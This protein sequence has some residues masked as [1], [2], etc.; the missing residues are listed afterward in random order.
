MNEGLQRKTEGLYLF[1]GFGFLILLTRLPLWAS[2]YT[3][4]D[5]T[6]LGLALSHYDLAAHRPHP[7]GYLFYVALGRVVHYLGLSP[8][9][10][11]LLL[12]DLF[13]VVGL[14]CVAAMVRPFTG[15]IG[16]VVAAALWCF[17]PILW[18]YGIVGESYA[19]EGACSALVGLLALRWLRTGRGLLTLSLAVGLCGGIRSSVT[20]FTFPLWLY[21]VLRR[22]PGGREMIYA[23]IS[24]AAGIV[25]WALPT[26]L[27]AGGYHAYSELS[28]ALIWEYVGRINS[29]FLS[30]DDRYVWL[31]IRACLYWLGATID[32]GGACA[33]FVALAAFVKGRVAKKSTVSQNTSAVEEKLPWSFVFVWT[34]P[35][36]LFFVLMFASKP[37]YF[38]VL[39]PAA[40]FVTS[41]II[42]HSINRLTVAPLFQRWAPI[43]I[44]LVLV[45][46]NVHLFLREQP[47][48]GRPI[49]R[50]V[51]LLDAMLRSQ[52]ASTAHL[53][54]LGGPR[55]AALYH[56]GPTDWRAAC[57]Y[58]PRIDTYILQTEQS[59]PGRPR[60]VCFCLC[61]SGRLSCVPPAAVPTDDE[62]LEAA[63]VQLHPDVRRLF[64]LIDDRS[65]VFR[66]L[67]EKIKIN[68]YQR[69][70]SDIPILYSDI[71]P[72]F[73]LQVGRFHLHHAPGGH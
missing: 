18:F 52:L 14:M 68:V 10:T 42:V 39:L 46:I 25:A 32:F 55:S 61:R 24:L 22:R 36:L 48:G 1:V 37:G 41:T 17:N 9:Q 5:A 54:P 35:A 43:I 38:L 13:T 50:T 45:S 7:P 73:S 49:A 29:P 6:Q 16:S 59:W 66:D 65:Q 23:T 67:R 47:F 21:C 57:V 69:S 3:N 72:S 40:V 71:P 20:V 26:V 63:E 70:E 12:A 33:A 2:Y 53:S 19:A 62:L 4:I 31:N 44:A 11:Y 34:L 15:S 51:A 64:W 56:F 28:H 30:V 27:L 8:E 58:A 60:G